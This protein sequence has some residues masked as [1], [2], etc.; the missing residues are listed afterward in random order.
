MLCPDRSKLL[1]DGVGQLLVLDLCAEEVGVG[2]LVSHGGGQRAED[3]IQQLKDLVLVGA[4]PAVARRLAQRALH[5]NQQGR[6]VDEPAHFAEDGARPVALTQ[7]RQQG[8]GGRGGDQKKRV[9][10]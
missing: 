5:G 4:L 1:P 9:G 2:G 7:H 8:L 3:G 6:D 10:G